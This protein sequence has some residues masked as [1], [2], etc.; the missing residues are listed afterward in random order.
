MN[1]PTD[2]TSRKIHALDSF[3]VG[4]FVHHRSWT[5]PRF[6]GDKQFP[7]VEKRPRRIMSI[8]GDSIRCGGGLEY[9]AYELIP[10]TWTPKS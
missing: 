2:S 3:R 7:V 4:Q 5:L 1:K 6:D 9:R 8:D 10:S